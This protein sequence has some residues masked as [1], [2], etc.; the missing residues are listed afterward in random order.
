VL[1]CASVMI[2][3]VMRKAT[4]N[5]GAGLGELAGSG[6]HRRQKRWAV[7]AVTT[8]HPRGGVCTAL[9]RSG[10]KVWVRK[11]AWWIAPVVVVLTMAALIALSGLI[12]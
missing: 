7:G 6:G 4:D 1:L 3:V 10:M 8:M 9:R 11:D 5:H 12:L 2:L